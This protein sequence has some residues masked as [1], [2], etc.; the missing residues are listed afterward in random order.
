MSKYNRQE[1]REI[2]KKADVGLSDGGL[3]FWFWLWLSLS[4]MMELNV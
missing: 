4:M 3:G 1:R 2:E